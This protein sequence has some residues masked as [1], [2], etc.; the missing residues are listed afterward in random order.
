[1]EGGNPGK[2]GNRLL[3]ITFQER[4]HHQGCCG[5]ADLWFHVNYRMTAES[6]QPPRGFFFFFF[7]KAVKGL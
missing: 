1:M 7:F 6:P 5:V 4:Q 3:L 2:T